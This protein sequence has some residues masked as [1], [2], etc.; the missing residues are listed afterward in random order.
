[1]PG[2]QNSGGHNKKSTSLHLLRG[3]FRG[4]R[5]GDHET[6]EP[7]RAPVSLKSPRSLAPIAREEWKRMV[8]R[9][10]TTGALTTVDDAALFQYVQLFEETEQ[11]KDDLKAYRKLAI[12][13]KKLAMEHLRGQELGTAIGRIID[14]HAIQQRC[15][16]QLRQGHVAIRQYLVEF[17]MTPSSRSRV[18]LPTGRKTETKRSKIDELMGA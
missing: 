10:T 3:T 14:L 18:K 2:N 13:L 4:D 7:P 9:L 12:D 1:M 15:Q 5:H 6:P 11:I 8:K 16:T 17:G